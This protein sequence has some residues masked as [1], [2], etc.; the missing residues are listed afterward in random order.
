MAGI[1]AETGKAIDGFD[2]VQQS[3]EVILTTPQ[4]TRVMREWFGNPGLK[5]LG[6]NMTQDTIMKWWSI[7]Y[8]LIEL[9]EPR[10]EI[11]QFDVESMNRDGTTGPAFSGRY[12]PYAL[13]DFVQARAFVSVSD[14]SVRLVIDEA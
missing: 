11:T 1:N 14:G 10:F 8:A 12:R 6:E 5:L 3:I 7:T 13:A 2:E 9:Y 4:G